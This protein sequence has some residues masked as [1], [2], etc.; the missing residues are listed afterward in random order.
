M[1]YV[2]YKG[3]SIMA[4]RGLL[5]KWKSH[6]VNFWQNPYKQISNHSF[7]FPGYLSGLRLNPSMVRSEMLENSFMIDAVIKRFDTIVP[8]LLLIRSLAN[9][10]LRNVSEHPI[11]KLVWA[12]STDSNILD[13]FGHICR[14]LF[15]YHSGSSKKHSLCRIN[16]YFD[17]RVPE[18]WLVNIKARHV[19]V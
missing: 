17:F 3:K 19:Q 18:L 6:L 7:Y 1:H 12:D 11:S 13:Q 8:T 2:R 9:V 15:Y 16:T 4:S 10:K 14:N 5:K